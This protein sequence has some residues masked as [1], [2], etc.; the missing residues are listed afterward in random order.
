MKRMWTTVI[1]AALVAGIASAL[2]AARSPR[3]AV[4]L[5]KT[6][7]GKILVD[8]HGFTVY[9]FTRDKRNVDSCVKVKGCL[10]VWPAVTSSGKP[11]GGPGVKAS[12]LGT[13]RLKHGVL[14]VTYAG[15]PLYTFGGD[16]HPGQTNNVNIYQ[17]GG[18]W[19]AVNA[20]GGEVK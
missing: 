9:A 13:I 8:A 7:L 17:Y 10:P 4:Q 12:L 16:S 18:R 6:K 14:Q 1:A 20:S 2:A 5:R 15:H 11:V 19:P 3:P